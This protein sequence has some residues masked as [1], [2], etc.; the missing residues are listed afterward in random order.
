MVH[1]C[2]CENA[3]QG[4]CFKQWGGG[5]GGGLQGEEQKEWLS[6]YCKYA[7]GV[8]VLPSSYA[9]SCICPP[10]RSTAWGLRS[11]NITLVMCGRVS[12]LPFHA[13]SSSVVNVDWTWFITI[14][15]QN[16]G[17]ILEY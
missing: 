10:N 5:G 7:Q 12:Q 14:Q 4:L 11:A 1:T 16:T 3:A 9:H 8:D 2:G 13:V 17:L 15:N 6:V